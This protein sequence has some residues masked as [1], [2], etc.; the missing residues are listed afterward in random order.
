MICEH[1]RLED[2]G[3]FHSPDWCF[4]WARPRV[5]VAEQPAKPA[6]LRGKLGVCGVRGC[7]KPTVPGKVLC[8]PCTRALAP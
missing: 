1:C 6:P 5:P 7:Y 3:G 8:S 4:D 2:Y